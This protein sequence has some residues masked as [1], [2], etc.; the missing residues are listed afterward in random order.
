MMGLG[1]VVRP[2]CQVI[3]ALRFVLGADPTPLIQIT[4]CGGELSDPAPYRRADISPVSDPPTASDFRLPEA[5]ATFRLCGFHRTDPPFPE[6]V[7][8][9]G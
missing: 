8:V 5:V 1:G 3:E 6:A 9:A 4:P 2:D 7:A